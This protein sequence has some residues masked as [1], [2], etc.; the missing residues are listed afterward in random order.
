MVVVRQLGLVPY[1]AG[2]AAQAAAA[3]E[4]RGG[5][6]DGVLLALRHTPVITMGRRTRPGDVHVPRW[7]RRALGIDLF[8]TDRGGGATFHHPA[9]AVVYPILHLGRL[10]LT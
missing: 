8:H 6:L 1:P 2:L 10:R 7:E 4:V 9:Q 3:D 5:A